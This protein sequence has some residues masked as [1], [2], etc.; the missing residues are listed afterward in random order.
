MNPIVDVPNAPL[1]VG[2][3]SLAVAAGGFV[4]TSGQIGLVPET[5]AMISAEVTS[6]TEQVL[7]NLAA[8]LEAAGCSFSDVVKSTIFLTDLS[9]FA[10]VNDIYSRALGD[11]RP[12]RST[13]QVAA[14]PKGACVE[15]EMI[16][17]TRG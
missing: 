11:A 10:V 3:Y 13:I 14:L 16:A 9:D 12:A 8:V 17:R 1:P 2:P 7:R 4:F 6:Q 15:I 5:G